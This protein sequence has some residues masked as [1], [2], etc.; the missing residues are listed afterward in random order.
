MKRMTIQEVKEIT[1]LSLQQ[2][3]N[4]TQIPY[5]RVLKLNKQTVKY[6]EI[7]YLRIKKF[8][9]NRGKNIIHVDFTPKDKDSRPLYSW[10][11][12]REVDLHE[13]KLRKRREKRKKSL[14]DI[15]DVRELFYEYHNNR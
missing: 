1:G 7:D 15:R 6:R 3:S 5:D 10:E 13:Y 4:K 14:H 11:R 12:S 8:M 9:D 2:I